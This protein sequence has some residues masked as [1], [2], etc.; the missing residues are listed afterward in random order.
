MNN[1]LLAPSRSTEI[2]EEVLFKD[3]SKNF[4]IAVLQFFYKPTGII[5][6]HIYSFPLFCYAYW[7]LPSP[8]Y[9]Q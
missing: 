3:K 2:E 6:S 1:Q 5:F 4:K 8:H 7:F 9:E